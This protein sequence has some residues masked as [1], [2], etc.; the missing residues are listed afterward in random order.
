M[1]GTYRTRNSARDVAVGETAVL[2]LDGTIRRGSHSQDD[3]DV[4][5]LRQ[6][7]D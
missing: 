2:V 3:G 4:I 1:V 6:T 7:E 5:V